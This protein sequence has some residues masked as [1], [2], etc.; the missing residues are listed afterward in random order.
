MSSL[1]LTVIDHHAE[2]PDKK[3]SILSD[4]YCT[5]VGGARIF[6][7]ELNPFQAAFSSK[8]GWL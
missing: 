8:K 4:V 6:S 2:Y 1:G 5:G 3:F 7:I